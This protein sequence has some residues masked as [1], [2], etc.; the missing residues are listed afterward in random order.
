MSH[1]APPPDARIASAPYNFVPV[2]DQ[3]VWADELPLQNRYDDECHTGHIDVTLRTLAPLFIRGPLSQ[4]HHAMLKREQRKKKA[5]EP[6]NEVLFRRLLA[7][8]TPYHH[9][10]PD[11]PVVPSSS[12][13]GMLRNVVV[14]ASCGRLDTDAD[15]PVFF[16]DF[17]DNDREGFPSQI[18]FAETTK[19]IRAGYL[20]DQEGSFKVRPA[21][22]ASADKKAAQAERWQWV[23]NG[24]Y[25]GS[26]AKIRVLTKGDHPQPANCITF[27]SGANFLSLPNDPHY[28]PDYYP[29]KYKLA[30]LSS[31]SHGHNEL[32]DVE[33]LGSIFNNPGQ[34]YE[35]GTL[36]LSGNM[37][38]TGGSTPRR[39]AALV[40]EP[41]GGRE[42]D[43]KIDSNSLKAVQNRYG[44]RMEH[45]CP[46]FYVQPE[47]GEPIRHFGFS[48]FFPLVFE[49]AGDSERDGSFT[50]AT[51]AS[52]RHPEHKELLKVDLA[53]ALFGF[54][55]DTEERG[56]EPRTVGSGAIPRQMSAHRGRVSVEDAFLD[57]PE[58]VDV[59]IMGR[60]WVP[61][62][63][64][65]PKP[66]AYPL[67]LEQPNEAFQ[68]G[69]THRVRHF[70]HEKSPAGR[71]QTL[72]APGAKRWKHVLCSFQPL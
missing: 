64:A 56:Q 16:R 21:R 72:L 44:D 63:L 11:R 58:Q 37:S 22:R 51:L 28:E 66:S 1:D 61:R 67:Y 9:G 50:P 52:R 41:V 12:L 19:S 46:V 17:A 42:S 38:E 33:R 8:P 43:L 49:E 18:T 55:P 57:P 24:R 36:V 26:A 13:T 48:P 2:Y 34:G 47:K 5:Q 29:V 45:G 20:V 14:A 25:K 4:K 53:D 39:N 65:S 7:D 40:L 15:D 3:V 68:S 62:T 71:L 30:T 69:G 23:Y 59:L 35:R 6:Y 31:Q 32:L 60:T 54:A 70:G 10:N 27:A